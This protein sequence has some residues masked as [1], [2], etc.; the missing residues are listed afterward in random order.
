MQPL[1]HQR[2]LAAALLLFLS[3]CGHPPPS[4]L[5]ALA[6]KLP[7]DAVV[8]A[9]ADLDRLRATSLSAKLPDAF[10][11]GSYLLAAYTGN[12]IATAMRAADG[13]IELSAPAGQGAP[14]DL[15]DRAPNAPLWIVA[16]GSATPPLAGNLA[17]LNRL[18][19]QTEYTVVVATPGDTIA[20]RADAFCRGDAAARHL[21]ENIRAI[22]SLTRFPVEVSREGANVHV[23]AA[24]SAESLAKL[25]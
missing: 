19:H 6:A 9:G 23:T 4:P 16:R 13:R 2:F 21:E 17:N 18:L 14:A 11:N 24:V 22:S 7:S 20:L 12:E 5:A 10:R 1:T 8:L 3:A 15:L 25:F